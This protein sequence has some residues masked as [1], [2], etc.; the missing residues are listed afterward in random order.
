VAVKD[1]I[2]NGNNQPEA[3]AAATTSSLPVDAPDEDYVPISCADYEILEIVCMDHYDL[4]LTTR[5]GRVV[6]GEAVDLAVTASEE[7]LVI[8]SENGTTERIR[9]DQVRV[10]TVVS[11]PSRFDEHTFQT[12][13]PAN[14][15]G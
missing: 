11:R 8:R 12:V 13:A 14:V 4:V 2:L 3:R 9:A 15:R 10:L 5:G 6:V 7:F 1:K